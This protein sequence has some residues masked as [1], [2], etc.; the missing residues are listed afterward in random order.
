MP[1]PGSQTK[2]IQEFWRA[3]RT[4][5][6]EARARAV[7]M[8]S[9]E[10]FGVGLLFSNC[11]LIGHVIAPCFIYVPTWLSVEGDVDRIL[12]GAQAVQGRCMGQQTI[13]KVRSVG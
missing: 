9:I 3:R 12:P 6:G 10:E 8:P 2:G 5:L 7:P 11:T 4:A 1:A 13:S